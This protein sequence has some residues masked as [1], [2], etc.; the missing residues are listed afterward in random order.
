VGAGRRPAGG[1][2]ALGMRALRWAALVAVAAGSFFGGGWLL[3]RGLSA[4]A[5]LPAGA[6]A[7]NLPPVVGSRLFQD[8]LRHVRSFAVDSLD[9]AAIYRLAASGMLDE[10]DDPYAALV[11]NEPG[12]AGVPLGLHLDQDDGRVVVV[13]V[14][15]GSPAD[16]AGVRG[17]DLVVDVGGTRVEGRSA[18]EVARLL[19]G[20]PGGEVSLLLLRS[21]PRR[22]RVSVRRGP[23]PPPP[24]PRLARADG[25]A[26]VRLGALGAA[27]ADR[28]AALVDSAVALGDR[29]LIL[30]V[31][32]VA[33]GELAAAVRAA[34]LFLPDTALVAQ[35]RGRQA[36]EVTLI[37]NPGAGRFPDLPVVVLVD[38]GTSG[39]AEVL[40]GALQDHDRALLVGEP[41]FGRGGDLSL[42]PV[43]DGMS[44]R[45]TT[46][47]WLTP[48]G[49]I[50]Q[51]TSRSA[52][53]EGAGAGEPAPR[54]EFRTAAGRTVVGGG[55]V[56]PDRA[57][58]P[59]DVESP[60]ADLA[61]GLARQL[62]RQARTTRS[63]LSQG[64]GA[65]P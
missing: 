4:R 10:L 29:G 43:G 28:L 15:P 9:E 34:G 12:A 44:L 8:V 32:G 52:P 54:P 48:L 3:R 35:S 20:P 18:D 47:H 33:E 50:I 38:G 22:L 37:R 55:G 11:S 61:L 21:G 23:V 5:A 2:G 14:R 41:T 26:H 24:S 40:A 62:L 56:V 42:Y 25:V 64:T 49:R 17:G 27:A 31:R 30:D 60:T 16:S 19:A 7:P 39:P 58:S 45:L 57:V 46:A 6:A 59:G 1:R 13:A 53:P 51:R 65:V 63:L 36:A